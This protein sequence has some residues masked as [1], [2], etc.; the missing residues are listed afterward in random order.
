MGKKVEMFLDRGT[1]YRGTVADPHGYEIELDD[2][3][4]VVRTTGPAAMDVHV[5]GEVDRADKRVRV[6]QNVDAVVSFKDTRG[7]VLS[8]LTVYG[9]T[10]VLVDERAQVV[11][12]RTYTKDEAKDVLGEMVSWL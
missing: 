9:R 8:G 11:A 10:R 5:K 2:P 1:F 12:Y 6:A 7:I 3:R 4:M